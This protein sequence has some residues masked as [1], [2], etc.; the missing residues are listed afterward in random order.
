M[1]GEKCGFVFGV[2]VFLRIG[3]GCGDW[4]RE[5][6][7]TIGG[8]MVTRNSVWND[9]GIFDNF[10]LFWYVKGVGEMMMCVLDCFVV[11][12]RRGQELQAARRWR[13]TWLM[14]RPSPGR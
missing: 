14:W 8:D 6:I 3:G 7:I 2:S 12:R 10:D 5:E 9:G 13:V 1:G 11:L 4:S